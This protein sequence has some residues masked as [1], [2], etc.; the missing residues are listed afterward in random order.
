MARS[1]P[2]QPGIIA[3]LSAV[4]TATADKSGA[5]AP[6]MMLV[7]GEPLLEYQISALRGQGISR[8]LLEVDSVAGSLLE[9]ADRLR[10]RGCQIEFVRST[11]DLQKAVDQNNALFVQTE[12]LYLSDDLLGS[13]LAQ[14][15]P[16]IATVDGRDENAAFERM[17]LN[18]RWAG[19]ALISAGTIASLENLPE[20][21]SITSSLL[22][23]AMR[24]ETRLLAL[25]QRHIQDGKLKQ[26]SSAAE[27]DLLSRQILVDR[28][29]RQGGIVER[30]I[31]A[32]IAARLAPVI[33]RHPSGSDG[34]DLVTMILAVATV[35]LAAAGW[36]IAAIIAAIVAMFGISIRAAVRDI[37]Q[38]TGFAKWMQ[39]VFWVLLAGAAVAAA[40]TGYGYSGHEIYAVTVMLGL[41]LLSQQLNLPVWAQHV[42]KS[43]AALALTLLCSVLILGFAESVQW[44]S[45]AQM[46][47][48]LVAKWSPNLAR[49]KAKQA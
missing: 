39:P 19:V 7:G 32:P 31:F 44:I 15:N 1:A 5:L 46:G 38:D 20:G 48:L 21:W 27:A 25:P 35:P 45:L 49:K 33:W 42:L 9:L 41:A 17:D 40:R 22:R 6:G 30:R 12:A 43:P 37:D 47:A 34:V 28:S 3:L 2:N 36:I 11:G 4:T 8:F 29:A 10:A 13:M 16:F 14:K 26:I 24:A 23:Q 18:T